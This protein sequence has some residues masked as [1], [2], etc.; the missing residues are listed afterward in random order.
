M[1]DGEI[2]IEGRA[3]K[4]VKNG[5]FEHDIYAMQIVSRSGLQQLQL[6]DGE[7][8]DAFIS[9]LA[10][11]AWE[12]GAAI[13]IM[14]ALLMPAEL[15]AVNWTPATARQLADFFR[16]VTDPESKRLLR[17]RIG[18]ILFGFFVS[19]LSFSKTSQKSL[20]PSPARQGAAGETAD[21]S[22]TAIGA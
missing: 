13:D 8:D 22:G 7:D 9:R 6:A 1:A 3:L 11:K 21:V 12:S 19:A 16:K 5:T 18:A 20:I 4:P 14:A 10:V 15:E 17:M 2:T